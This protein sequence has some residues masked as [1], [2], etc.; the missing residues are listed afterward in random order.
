MAF[1]DEM[2]PDW[3]PDP[4][5][6]DALQDLGIDAS[7][8]SLDFSSATPSGHTN[9][10]RAVTF[11]SHE[12]VKVLGATGQPIYRGD[13]DFLDDGSHQPPLLFW[14]RLEAFES[15]SWRT[16]KDDNRLPERVW[17]AVGD[18]VR[19]RWMWIGYFQP[20]AS[21]ANWPEN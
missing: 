3:N 7:R 1:V 6:L 18:D 17:Q 4:L 20:P 13:V 5:W 8:L 15:G 2:T 19:A 16:M 10:Y 12:N 14:T 21:H 11:E 9:A